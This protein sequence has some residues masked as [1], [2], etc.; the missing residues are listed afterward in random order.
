MACFEVGHGCEVDA[1]ME[2]WA[3][4]KGSVCKEIWG[5]GNGMRHAIT[6][7]VADLQALQS[8]GQETIA[9]RS[10]ESTSIVSTS[11]QPARNLNGRR[12]SAL[13]DLWRLPPSKK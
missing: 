2:N 13:I 10:I 9:L 5:K 3:A 1:E 7:A 11:N 12:E 6:G 4:G 8:D